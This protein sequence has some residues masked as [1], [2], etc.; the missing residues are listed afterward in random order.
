[1]PCANRA[2]REFPSPALRSRWPLGLRESFMW[3]HPLAAVEVGSM[4]RTAKT[5]VLVVLS[6]AI[7]A[8]TIVPAAVAWAPPPTARP[9][10][11]VSITLYGSAESGSNGWGFGPTNITFPGPTI[12]VQQG[13]VIRFRL[14]SQD[15][16]AHTLVV[17]TDGDGVADTGEQ[18]DPFSSSSQAVLFNYTA[19]TAGSITYF[20][21]IHGSGT[22]RG[23][24]VVEAPATG[25]NTLLIVGGL[26]AVVAVVAVAAAAMR[27]RKKSKP[28]AQ[29][30]TQ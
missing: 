14:F 19:P 4:A 20:C 5:F 2:E 9:T 11:D 30:P 16:M 8:S 29:P 23:T 18:S 1:M 15:A 28:P 26:V 7:V 10:K 17:D 24:L 22:Q 12:T 13:D 21:G 3:G 25:D 27:M 6:F